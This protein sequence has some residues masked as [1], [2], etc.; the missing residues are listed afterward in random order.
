MIHLVTLINPVP[1]AKRERIATLTRLED[2]VKKQLAEEAAR[3]PPRTKQQKLQKQME[4][5]LKVRGLRASRAPCQPGSAPACRC[6][7]ARAPASRLA[8]RAMVA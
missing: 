2:T 5:R 1:Q 7:T 6:A 3:R 4:L 8:P